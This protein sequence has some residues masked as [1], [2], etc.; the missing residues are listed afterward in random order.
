MGRSIAL[1]T[2]TMVPHPRRRPHSIFSGGFSNAGRLSLWQ[3]LR[4]RWPASENLHISGPK[5]VRQNRPEHAFRDLRVNT[6]D[7]PDFVTCSRKKARQS[8][9]PRAAASWG[10]AKVGG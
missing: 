7:K 3:A 2:A 5:L 9:G 6:L 10:N 4:V 8:A 1:S